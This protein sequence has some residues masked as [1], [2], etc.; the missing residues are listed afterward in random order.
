MLIMVEKS[1]VCVSWSVTWDLSDLFMNNQGLE[2]VG[3]LLGRAREYVLLFGLT[4]DC[5][6]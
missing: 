4:G 6:K 2:Q 3:H 5:G 1:G